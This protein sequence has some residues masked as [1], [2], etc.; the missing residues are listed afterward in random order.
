MKRVLKAV[1]QRRISV[2]VRFVNRF[3]CVVVVVG[4]DVM[5]LVGTFRAVSLAEC[6]L[7]AS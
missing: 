3:V 7:D 1:K 4:C 2:F 6:D 5:Y